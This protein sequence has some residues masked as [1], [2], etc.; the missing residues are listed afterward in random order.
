MPACTA[1]TLIA[2]TLV[3]AAAQAAAAEPDLPKRK[4]GLWETTVSMPGMP[5]GAMPAM[6]MCID[7]ATDDLVGGPNGAGREHCEKVD[8]RHESARYVIESVCRFGETKTHTTGWFEGSFDS[9]YHGE[10]NTTYDP[11]MQGMKDGKVV[12]AG[13]WLGACPADMKPG[14]M[15]LPNGMKINPSKMPQGQPKP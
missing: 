6:K 15:L 8:I 2:V 5:G 1:R 14:D 11:P 12:I 7:A 9:D 13:R 3:V 4:P 10:L